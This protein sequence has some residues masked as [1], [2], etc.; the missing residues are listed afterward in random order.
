M[1][2]KTLTAFKNK[3]KNIDV[4]FVVKGVLVLGSLYTA[5]KLFTTI[6]KGVGLI[7]DPAEVKKDI[8]LN[9]SIQDSNYVLSS[10]LLKELKS[11]GLNYQDLNQDLAKKLSNDFW[12]SWKFGVLDEKFLLNIFSQLKY[13]SQVSIL[14]AW[15]EGAY[16]ESLIDHITKHLGSIFSTSADQTAIQQI[17]D[18]IK[19]LPLGVIK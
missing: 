13:Q 19:K 11:K 7:K 17:F 2:S 16:G 10:A 12:Y 8:E 1:S 14:S 4:N 6:F 15:V 3:A 18:R 5:Y 9:Q